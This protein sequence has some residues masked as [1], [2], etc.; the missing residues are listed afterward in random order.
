MDGQVTVQ[1][2]EEDADDARVELVT[3]YLREELVRIDVDAVSAVREGEAP[4]GSRGLDVAALGGLVVSLGGAQTVRAVVTAIRAWLRRSPQL[5]R[6]VRVEIDGDVLELSGASSTDQ[7]RLV[8]LFL[9]RH[10]Q[11]AEAVGP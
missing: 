10:G 1:V 5:P 6:T 4:D 7:E 2:L 11:P 3:R 9:S 8:G